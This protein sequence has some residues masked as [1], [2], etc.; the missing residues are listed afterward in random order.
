M[1]GGEHAMTVSARAILTC[2]QLARWNH[3]DWK[4]VQPY[5]HSSRYILTYVD[6]TLVAS[7]YLGGGKFLKGENGFLGSFCKS[8]SLENSLTI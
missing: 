8:L 2:L 7:K 4:E 3:E 6:V 1:S 5:D